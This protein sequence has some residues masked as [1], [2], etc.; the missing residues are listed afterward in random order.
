MKKG[1]F[2]GVGIGPGC[3]DL[4]TVKGMKIL[5]KENKLN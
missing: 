3:P 1:K 5:Q 4:I 2:F